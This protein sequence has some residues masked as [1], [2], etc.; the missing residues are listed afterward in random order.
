MG[1]EL[2]PPGGTS[3]SPFQPLGAGTKA[4]ATVF[5]EGK[6]EPTALKEV[7]LWGVGVAGPAVTAR[8]SVPLPRASGVVAIQASL[9]VQSPS[10]CK[11]TCNPGLA[12]PG[13]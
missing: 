10:W 8:E 12:L 9:G 7:R 4:K 5:K 1:S 13:T 2:S 6:R 11:A 3:Q